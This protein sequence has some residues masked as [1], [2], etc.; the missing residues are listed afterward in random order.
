MLALLQLLRGLA[1]HRVD[2]GPARRIGR[3]V[4]TRLFARFVVFLVVL[5]ILMTVAYLLGLI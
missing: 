1:D 3:R 5:V 4:F 2:P